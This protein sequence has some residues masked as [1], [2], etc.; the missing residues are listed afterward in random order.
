MIRYSRPRIATFENING[1][2]DEASPNQPRYEY[3][4]EYPCGLKFGDGDS[5]SIPLVANS[6]W[7]SSGG[8]FV[9]TANAP[10]GVEFIFCGDVTITGHG[11]MKTEI[12][13]LEPEESVSPTVDIFPDGDV[14][15]EGEAH[16]LTVKYYADQID[17]SQ[18]DEFTA[19]EEL[20]Q[21]MHQDWS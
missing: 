17:F 4:D 2:I 21:F 8:T 6:S 11:A 14:L 20:N 7:I 1:V 10:E 5:A 15:D 19:M 13:H 18:Y 12:I 9:V 3:K 16:L